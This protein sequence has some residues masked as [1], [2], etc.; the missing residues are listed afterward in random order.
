MSRRRPLYRPGWLAPR[1]GVLARGLIVVALAL[2]LC[3]ALIASAHLPSARAP[4]VD[5]SRM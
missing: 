1:D 3:G 2:G 5:V 4:R